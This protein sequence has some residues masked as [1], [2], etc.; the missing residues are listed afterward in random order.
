MLIEVTR[1][2]VG[3]GQRFCS[4]SCP[5]A[6]AIKRSTG[7]AHV[8]VAIEYVRLAAENRTHC[9]ISLPFDVGERISAFDRG[10]G[11]E[12]FSFELELEEKI[13][14]EKTENSETLAI[15]PG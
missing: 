15:S 6:V 8:S 12:P 14:E 11:M 13:S 1:G 4:D 2:D 10:E 3:N 5:V 9:L 7:L